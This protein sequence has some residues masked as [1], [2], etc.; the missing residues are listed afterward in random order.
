MGMFYTQQDT[1]K[2][3]YK[4]AI[5]YIVRACTEDNHCHWF[6]LYDETS[7]VQMTTFREMEKGMKERKERKTKEGTG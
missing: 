3:I 1:F 4:D 6:F 5:L 7:E 2:N